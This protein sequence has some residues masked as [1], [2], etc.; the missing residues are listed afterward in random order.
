MGFTHGVK[1]NRSNVKGEPTKFP[2]SYNRMVLV[3][4]TLSPINPH[5]VSNAEGIR[6]A[7][8]LAE[9][10]VEHERSRKK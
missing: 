1:P 3:K 9:K 2:E 8:E 10:W 5:I 4:K 6:E 7:L